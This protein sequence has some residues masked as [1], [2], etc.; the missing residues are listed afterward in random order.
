M[1]SKVYTNSLTV[2]RLCRYAFSTG[3]V[4]TIL[5]IYAYHL[6]HTVFV[7]HSGVRRLFVRLGCAL[8]SSH[9]RSPIPL[10]YTPIP[11]FSGRTDSVASRSRCFRCHKFGHWANDCRVTINWSNFVSHSRGGFP[12]AGILHLLAQPE[13]TKLPCTTG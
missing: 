5:H 12:Y 8:I 11:L 4:I 9:Y 7:R 10:H 6:W 2:H 1:V 13:E 3:N